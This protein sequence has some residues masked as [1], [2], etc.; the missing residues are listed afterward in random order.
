M[1]LFFFSCTTSKQHQRPQRSRGEKRFENG[2]ISFAWSP[3]LRAVSHPLSSTS[4]YQARSWASSCK[5]PQ[6]QRCCLHTFFY[7]TIILLACPPIL[8]LS[9]IHPSVRP[10]HSLP[11]FYSSSPVG[12]HCCVRVAYMAKHL[13]KKPNEDKN[14]SAPRRAP[15]LRRLVLFSIS[16]TLFC[17][18]D[19]TLWSHK[20]APRSSVGYNSATI[21]TS[22]P[23]TGGMQ[24][25]CQ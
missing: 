5:N 9:T 18:T 6:Q 2:F 19:Q 12:D 13:K 11:F 24:I 3:P 25:P 15:S 1:L 16:M 7:S 23:Y 14:L 10:Q 20:R 17:R 21:N 22:P 4:V 8:Q